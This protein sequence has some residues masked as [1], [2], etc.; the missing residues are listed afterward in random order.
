MKANNKEKSSTF[1]LVCAAGTL[2]VTNEDNRRLFGIN[3]GPKKRMLAVV[4]H[5]RIQRSPP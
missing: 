2:D 1:S 5:Q 4:I 3:V